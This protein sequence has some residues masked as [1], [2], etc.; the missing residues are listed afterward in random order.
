LRADP[1]GFE[2]GMGILG[3]CY[4]TYHFIYDLG[5]P[6]FIQ[7]YHGE[8]I[9]QFAKAVV[10]YKPTPRQAPNIEGLPEVVPELCEHKLTEMSVY[11]YDTHLDPVEADI[12]YK[13]FDTSCY[14]GE[15]EIQGSDAV[16]TGNFPQCVN[17]YVIASAPGYKTAKY[18]ESSVQGK[19]VIM[20]LDKKYNLN[21]EV[22]KDGS[23]LNNEY[24]IVTFSG[25]D[26]I[27]AVYPDQKNIE[28]TTG[29]YEVRVYVYTNS[30]INLEGSVREECVDVPKSGFLSIFG[31]EEEKC[32]TME[33]PDQVVSYAVSG[34]G[35][36]NYY[37]TESELETGSL[38]IDV[39]DFGKPGKVEELQIN[40]N[41]IQTE[42]LNLYFG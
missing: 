30:T 37:V 35:T 38:I 42:N 17:G 13:C 28:L 31:A 1:V 22:E 20:I 8:E 16:L 25:H 34:G 18:V 29:E 6:V 33:I 32:F 3:C 11:T 15:S 39:S 41:K 12:K 9:F 40:Y 26:T 36:S 24:A 7:S 10:I 21:L 2:E 5:Y 4:V 23:S 14:I 27:T 19:E